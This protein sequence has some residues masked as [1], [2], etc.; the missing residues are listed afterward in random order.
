MA[1]W[2]PRRLTAAGK[3]LDFKKVVYTLVIAAG[4]LAL[5]KNGYNYFSMRAQRDSLK[6][7]IEQLKNKNDE[8]TRKAQDLYADKDYVEKTAREQLGLAKDG[9]T[10]IV[11]KGDKKQ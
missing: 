11:I 1:N 10:V 6:A 3:G 5:L 2:R 7:E 8:L 4:V 9:E